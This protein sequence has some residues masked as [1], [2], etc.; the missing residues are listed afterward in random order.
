MV[1]SLPRKRSSLAERVGLD[2]L[3]ILVGNKPFPE[4][5]SPFPEAHLP[6]REG[7]ARIREKFGDLHGE[8]L[9]DA[10]AYCTDLLRRE[11]DRSAKIEAKAFTLI[12][13][14]GLTTAFITGFVGLLLDQGKMPSAVI[15]GA[16]TTL[17]VI[18]VASLMLTI[19]LAFRA[20]AVGDY[21]FMYPSA[22]DIFA[23]STGCLQYVQRERVVDLFLS[24]AH[25]V[26]EIN[27][28]ATY[29]GGAQVWFRNS[30][31]ALLLLALSLA[32]YIPFRSPSPASGTPPATPVQGL[33]NTPQATLPTTSTPSTTPVQGLAGTPQATL[34]ISSTPTALATPTVTFSPTALPPAPATPTTP[35]GSTPTP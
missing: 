2:W 6:Y 23:L 35:L 18:V 12:G 13:I 24:F 28:K 25:N 27:R 3:L 33:V 5:R 4:A 1:P 32:A 30:L 15:I 22:N 31:I 21:R 11:E 19:Y 10:L 26:G 20:V 8:K 17:F 29:L 14:T 34:P 9:D 16:A 7:R